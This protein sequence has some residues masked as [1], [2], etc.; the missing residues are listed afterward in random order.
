MNGALFHRPAPGPLRVLRAGSAAA[1]TAL[2]LFAAGCSGIGA[3][4]GQGKGGH[5]D[6][7]D[8][9]GD[10]LRKKGAEVTPA[11][12]GQPAQIQPGG[13]SAD[14]FQK[15]LKACHVGGGEG[16][17]QLTEKQKNEALAYAKC[18]RKQGLDFPDPV[19]EGGGTRVGNV[20]QMDRGKF[21]KASQICNAQG[22]GK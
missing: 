19:F 6:T 11:R 21:D 15:A 17:T 10:C 1:F 13:L 16:G 4:A 2:A 20:G 3:E 5:E 8:K 12:E 22:P 18:M 14:E 7:Q 9:Q